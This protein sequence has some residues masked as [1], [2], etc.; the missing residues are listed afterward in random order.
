MLSKFYSGWP[1]KQRIWPLKAS[2]LYKL[3]FHARDGGT[4]KWRL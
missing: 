1:T 3:S 4:Q 2:K